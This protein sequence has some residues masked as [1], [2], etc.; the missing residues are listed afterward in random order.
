MSHERNQDF[1]LLN[2]AFQLHTKGIEA[3]VTERLSKME[4]IKFRFSTS[5][6]KQCQSWNVTEKSFMKLG[7]MSIIPK[8]RSVGTLT[9][10]SI[11][12]SRCCVTG[13]S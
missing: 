7:Q 6:I 8:H 5:H 10:C 12:E 13:F 11:M 9:K 1:H 3:G 4:V 2:I